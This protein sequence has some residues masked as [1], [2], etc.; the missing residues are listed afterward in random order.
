MRFLSSIIAMW[1]LFASIAFAI[2]LTQ[3]L[4]VSQYEQLVVENGGV[5]LNNFMIAE[6]EAWL[7]DYMTNIEISFS[8]RNMTEVKHHFVVMLA[9]LDST[10]IVWTAAIEPKLSTL[11]KKTT[12]PL[13]KSTYV[14]PGS[15]LK[16]KLI[17]I[18]VLGTF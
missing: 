7:T 4:T 9:G 1:L 12:E 2:D 11:G 10:S 3:I 15:L 13:K 18:R 17:W 5:T 8:A 6:K 14:A 16:T